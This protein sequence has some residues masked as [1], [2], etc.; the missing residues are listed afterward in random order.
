MAI[1]YQREFTLI[2]LL[3]KVALIAIL[4]ATNIAS[5]DQGWNSY[6]KDHDNS[7]IADD[8]VVPPLRLKWKADLGYLQYPSYSRLYY[9]G[10]K[11]M[12]ARLSSDGYQF[13]YNAKP[14]KMVRAYNATT[15]AY[16]WES[17][18]PMWSAG[19][20]YGYYTTGTNAE[21]V[22]KDGYIWGSSGF[23]NCR[24]DLSNGDTWIL[25]PY[26]TG[27]HN[28]YV[29]ADDTSIYSM[30]FDQISDGNIM[31]KAT[32]VFQ[33]PVMGHVSDGKFGQAYNFPGVFTTQDYLVA[34]DVLSPRTSDWTVMFWFNWNGVY[35]EG[36]KT[37]FAKGNRIVDM[38]K[39]YSALPSGFYDVFSPYYKQSANAYQ[40]VN[41]NASY[42]AGIS[43]LDPYF[44]VDGQ[45][46]F[47]S[48]TTQG[49]AL[50]MFDPGFPFYNWT[51][52]DG[53]IR[54]SARAINWT[55]V[56]ANTWY[57]YA[58]A[59]D[60]QNI[61]IY[62]NG[63]L[64][65]QTSYTGDIGDDEPGTFYIGGF[66]ELGSFGGKIDE[67]AVFNEALSASEIQSL[68]SAP[69]VPTSTTQMLLHFD[70]D[71][72][73]GETESLIHDYSGNEKHATYDNHVNQKLRWKT[74]LSNP[75]NM[76]GGGS[77]IN[78]NLYGLTMFPG[79]R[80]YGM[81]DIAV[82]DGVLYVPNG[83]LTAY[84]ATTGDILWQRGNYPMS[85][86]PSDVTV[87][88]VVYYSGVVYSDGKVYVMGRESEGPI[89]QTT[90]TVG[91]GT[92]VG[93]TS[94]QDVSYC[95]EF[96]APALYSFDAATG[97]QMKKIP[98]PEYAR[99]TDFAPFSVAP[100]NGRGPNYYD[101]RLW[102][103]TYHYQARDLDAR[104][105]WESIIQPFQTIVENGIAYVS[106][107]DRIASYD[108]ATGNTLWEYYR[109][110][111][112]SDLYNDIGMSDS[113]DIILS[114]NL[115]Y[116]IEQFSNEIIALNK[117]NG[118]V[119][120]RFRAPDRTE[121]F[122]GLIEADHTIFASTYNNDVLYAFDEIYQ[123]PAI[124]N[125]S[126]ESIM[127]LAYI[128]VNYTYDFTAKDGEYPFTWSV[129]AGRLPAGLSI[130]GDNVG[131]LSGAPAE[132]G[133][134]S[135]TVRITD[136][137]G[138]HDDRSFTLRVLPHDAPVI[139]FDPSVPANNFSQ[140]SSSVNIKLNSS[141]TSGHFS[142]TDYDRSN[143][144]WLP[145]NGIDRD[146]SFGKAYLPYVKD[147]SSYANNAAIMGNPTWTPYG[148]CAG[149]YTF[150]GSSYLQL[151]NA[152]TASNSLTISLWASTNAIN[153]SHQALI[154]STPAGC[155]YNP[156][157]YIQ[158]GIVH[159]YSYMYNSSDQ[160]EIVDLSS[161]L[162][163][164]DGNWHQ[165]AMALDKAAKTMS[166]YVDGTL[167]NIAST[168]DGY[169]IKELGTITIGS[170]LNG[171]CQAVN[172]YIGK[173]DEVL[174]F[175]RALAPGEISS[176]YDSAS[177]QYSNVF[178]DLAPG[179][180]TFSAYA[181]DIY[182]NSSQTEQRSITVYEP[183]S[184]TGMTW[185]LYQ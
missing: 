54:T 35:N 110:N 26:Y 165:I 34:N 184:I 185:S 10:G 8:A 180:H 113:G 61:S 143:L 50:D 156:R 48:L 183:V 133:D 153:A 181:V 1:H 152:L 124:T 103:D 31:V 151:A 32:D 160:Y 72:G 2:D 18:C 45:A 70:N 67:F 22:I 82:H 73:V 161:N 13:G 172:Y 88:G 62:R 102:T 52:E 42:I 167:K 159:A 36:P 60:H 168:P 174:M 64:V 84:N 14:D 171:S 92:F 140:T 51:S 87:G 164:S 12:V 150:D 29:N 134:F 4:A 98:M 146:T 55:N 47:T 93:Y 162:N 95:S 179:T 19:G 49:N 173:M 116:A 177:N 59:Y 137:Q 108:T 136:A 41:F 53:Y 163:I 89:I 132:T 139:D 118:N 125:P 80:G 119:V 56:A 120:W 77:G 46:V 121:K 75:P 25:D 129:S 79:G 131:H 3:I 68:Y 71:P 81:G 155:Y 142:F 27:T 9:G 76:G 43:L 66:R 24:I 63:T 157:I 83:K 135:F 39:F 78:G 7:R 58:V 145:M 44:G 21:W 15:G 144:L 37:F 86:H 104:R 20:G 105:I 130:T 127:Q 17:N 112:P 114:G 11:V 122:T 106:A 126:D 178:T 97:T 57:H 138:N 176:L 69:I 158:N 109:S 147:Y 99:S 100:F 94:S 96:S 38:S 30:G 170:M 23:E 74:P 175:S 91:S 141:A 65:S 16:L 6:S 148:Y 107:T 40:A 5:G 90:I 182:G 169:W 33:M 111:V 85:D 128:G 149:A 123:N 117:S 115:I 28:S 166:I 154:N 101:R